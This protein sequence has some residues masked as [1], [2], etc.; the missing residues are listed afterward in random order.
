ML[1][2]TPYVIFYYILYALMLKSIAFNIIEFKKGKKVISFILLVL[3]ELAPN[4]F[5][6]FSG[7]YATGYEAMPLYLMIFQLPGILI[8]HLWAKGNP[9]LNFILMW[10]YGQGLFFM[11]YIQMCSIMDIFVDINKPVKAY[12]SIG[13][14]ALALS[15][16]LITLISI[17]LGI[18][19]HRI[20]QGYFL[21]IYKSMVAVLIAMIFEVTII[22]LTS[23]DISVDFYHKRYTSAIFSDIFISIALVVV[24]IY[25]YRKTIKRNSRLFEKLYKN[26]SENMVNIYNEIL[27][28]QDSVRMWRH[29]IKN[30]LAILDNI[31]VSSEL[32]EKTTELVDKT[33]LNLYVQTQNPILDTLINLKIETA[34]ENNISIDTDI[35]YPS[36]GNT[37]IENV[38]LICLFSNLLDN[39]IES[40][41]RVDSAERKISLHVTPQYNL[42]YINLV[43]SKAETIKSAS[44][45]FISTKTNPNEH[46][47]GT[48]IID[49]IVKKY[50][51]EI[52]YS[53]SDS[54]MTVEA[55]IKLTE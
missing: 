52:T 7:Y 6:I 29:D 17:I 41:E 34:L 37:I 49:R 51:G 36:S 55:I 22:E 2:N 33:K 31:N 12:S 50:N 28:S 26:N 9:I 11:G 18:I 54:D 47:L 53:E 38:D 30:H 42:L 46:G 19:Y 35:F 45:K 48:Q 39:A 32:I 43:N 4:M 15:F 10:L 24:L 44:G 5:L 3:L 8:L 20:L 23:Y 16:T 27:I 13:E 21:S 1:P 40:A 25:M 14:I